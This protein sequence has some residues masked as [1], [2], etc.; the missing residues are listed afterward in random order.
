MPELRCADCGVAVARRRDG[1]LFHTDALPQGVEYHTPNVDRP[2]EPDAG[3]ETMTPAERTAQAME[4]IADAVERLVVIE[5]AREE[6][7][8]WTR[9]G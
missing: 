9:R 8:G 4:R 5:T 6:R 2:F 7:G 3:E 1:A